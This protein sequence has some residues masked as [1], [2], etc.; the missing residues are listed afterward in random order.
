MTDALNGRNRKLNAFQVMIE[1]RIWV[2]DGRPMVMQSKRF[3]PIVC[4]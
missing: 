2:A 3:T 1:W 4:E